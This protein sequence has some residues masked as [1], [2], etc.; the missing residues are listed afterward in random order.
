GAKDDELVFVSGHP[1][2]TSRLNT[3]DHL[4]FFRDRYYPLYLNTLRRMEV[5]MKTYSDRSI[6]NERRSHDEYFSVQN[7]RKLLL[8]MLDGLQDPTIMEKKEAEEKALRD[9]VMKD[10]KLKEA[11]GDAWDLIAESVKQQEHAFGPY[12][13]LEA[14]TRGLNSGR[15]FNSKLFG[16]ARTLVR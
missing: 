7:S 16:I 2:R 9:T 14:R 13:L 4:K 6:E 3:V 11:Y 12:F 15:A 5:A 10:D 1:G 8:G